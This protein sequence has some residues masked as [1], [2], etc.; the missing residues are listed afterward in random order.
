M[1]GCSHLPLDQVGP[2]LLTNLLLTS[3]LLL[4]YHC[5]H[6]LMRSSTWF[7]CRPLQQ[8]WLLWTSWAFVRQNHNK[9]QQAYC[10]YADPSQKVLGARTG[11]RF[12]KASKT[13]TPAAAL[14]STAP[15]RCSTS[16]LPGSTHGGFTQEHSAAGRQ[17]IF[18]C[19][20]FAGF[21]MFCYLIFL[22]RANSH[23]PV[24]VVRDLCQ[25][26]HSVRIDAV[27]CLRLVQDH[28]KC[29]ISLV[30]GHVLDASCSHTQWEGS[31]TRCVLDSQA[32]PACSASAHSND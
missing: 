20:P 21:H 27:C 22:P 16:C 12:C 18:A 15:P 14:E 24:A 32:N 9:L 8:S 3:C 11:R 17:S 13:R 26:K 4:A 30:A 28:A 23:S 31:N 10:V 2:S 6:A 25:A 29:C 7:L 1:A 19:V 5:W